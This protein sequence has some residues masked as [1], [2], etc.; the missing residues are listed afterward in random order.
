MLP[1]QL[2]SNRVNAEDSL[3]SRDDGRAASARELPVDS[4]RNSSSGPSSYNDALNLANGQSQSRFIDVA[5]LSGPVTP[6]VDWEI[7]NAASEESQALLLEDGRDERESKL[8]EAGIGSSSGGLA[9]AS[10]VKGS[11]ADVFA[12]LD[13]AR[14]GKLALPRGTPIR[15]LEASAI[16]KCKRSSS[17]RGVWF[18]IIAVRKVTWRLSVPP[19][20]KCWI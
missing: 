14:T 9:N 15:T 3:P 18:A 2:L 11:G 20:R 5:P 8:R 13:Q 6:F 12:G 17:I 16:E 4:V 19:F 1:Q 10:E 7:Q